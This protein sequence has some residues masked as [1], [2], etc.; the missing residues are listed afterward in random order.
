MRCHCIA[1][2]PSTVTTANNAA[3]VPRILKC[4]RR[5]HDS[6]GFYG[7]FHIAVATPIAIPCAPHNNT[8]LPGARHCEGKFYSGYNSTI[9]VDYGVK[10]RQL[11]Y[12]LVCHH[13]Q[14]SAQ[15]PFDR[16]FITL[17]TSTISPPVSLPHDPDPTFSSPTCWTG[18]SK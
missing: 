12:R 15:T 5:R 2:P 17:P 18:K 9:G 4:H 7:C 11:V 10:V 3:E 1:L 13:P 16:P 6:F 14:P 8:A